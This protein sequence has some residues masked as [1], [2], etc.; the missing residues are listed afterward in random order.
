LVDRSTGG[1]GRR[2]ADLRV[3]VRAG[4][5]FWPFFTPALGLIA[6]LALVTSFGTPPRHLAWPVAASRLLLMVSIATLV[7][8]RPA[9]IGIVVD[10][11]AGRTPEAGAAEAHW[12]GGAK[13]G[14]DSRRCGL[15]G[16]GRR[17]SAALPLR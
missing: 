9:I 2:E 8:F 10:H 15:P 3:P 13:L 16:D 12:P 1:A 11:G 17:P 4:H 7:Y 5:V 6:L 14:A